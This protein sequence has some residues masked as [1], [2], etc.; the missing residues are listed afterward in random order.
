MRPRACIAWRARATF[1]AAMAVAL[2]ASIEAAAQTKPLLVPPKVHEPSSAEGAPFPEEAQK[3]G[4][5]GS[6]LLQL[7]VDAAGAVTGARVLE[8]AGHGF[9]EAALGAAK[10]LVFEPATKDGMPIPS[11]L[12]YRFTFT[13]K[14]PEPPPTTKPPE[15]VKAAKGALRVTVK[16]ASSDAPLAGV[17]RVSL[18]ALGA[19]GGEPAGDAAKGSSYAVGDDGVVTIPELSPGKYR[20]I[21]AAP[22]FVGAQADEEITAGDRTEVTYRLAPEAVAGGRPTPPCRRWRSAASGRRAR[23]PCTRSI[24]ASCRASR[25][26]TATPS[27]AC[28]RCRASRARA[29]SASS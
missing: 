21:I 29:G 20:V 18:R 3:A 25:G 11:K 7:D 23:S 16:I 10:K 9:D 14:A 5:S 12:N 26:P 6:V 2:L 15:P 27:A 28:S 19:P 13:W 24:S 1:G 22:G 17:A 4:V 8:P